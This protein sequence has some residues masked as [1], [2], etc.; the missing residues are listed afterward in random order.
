[1]AFIRIITAS[2]GFPVITDIYYKNNSYEINYD[3]KRDVNNNPSKTLFQTFNNL[4]INEGY[5]TAYSFEP[6][7]G[8]VIAK[9]G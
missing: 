9:V 8:I 4:K 7:D 2:N 6:N 3:N 5:L 1:N